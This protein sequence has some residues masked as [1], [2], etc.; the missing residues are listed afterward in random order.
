MRCLALMTLACAP[1]L[2]AASCQTTGPALTDPCDVL[3]PLDPKPATNGYIVAND[4]SFAVGVA[5]HRG[6]YAK[7]RC[8]R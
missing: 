2:A 4:R 7:Y 1:F 3:V 8:G 5:Q 6:R